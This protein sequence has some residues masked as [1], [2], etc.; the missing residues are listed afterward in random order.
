MTNS[1]PSDEKTPPT[2]S[3][4]PPIHKAR[5][6]HST[7][8]SRSIPAAELAKVPRQQGTLFHHGI[9]AA[10]GLVAAAYFDEPFQ[11]ETAEEEETQWTFKQ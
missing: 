10:A 6:I 2:I 4:H 1:I 9:D 7:P 3:P 11:D 5:P 8:S